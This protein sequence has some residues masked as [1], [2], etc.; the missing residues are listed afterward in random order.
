[1]K[2]R[3][4]NE[5]GI[6]MKL[7]TLVRWPALLL[8]LSLIAGCGVRS[9]SDSGYA[10]DSSHGRP[11]A[12]NPFYK[13]ELNEFEV[14]GIDRTQKITED[15]I[16]KSFDAKRP[17]SIPKGSS[18]LLVQSGATF[19]DDEM[20]RSLEKYYTVAAFTGVPDQNTLRPSSTADQ[21][22]PYF[23][24]LRLAAAKGGYEKIV[25]YWGILETAREGLGTKAVSWVPF[26][27]AAIPDENQRMRIRLKVAVVDVKSGQWEMFAPD[28]LDDE[29]ASAHYTRESSDQEQVAMLKDK[30]YQVAA[31]DLVKRYARAERAGA[32]D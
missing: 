2:V 3:C 27:G 7:Q 13:G 5:K 29:S 31:E 26:I 18:I 20:V 9:I 10:S 28:S 4:S 30:A 19:P 23:M 8:M 12:S 1:M 17:L 25:A 22:A 32:A 21:A 6:S 11:G 16:R 24:A 14:L 15:D